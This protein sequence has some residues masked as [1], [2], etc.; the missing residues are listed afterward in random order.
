MLSVT[1]AVA[2]AAA[3]AAVVAKVDG[4]IAPVAVAADRRAVSSIRLVAANRS[5]LAAANSRL[6][7]VSTSRIAVA[8]A[9]ATTVADVVIVTVAAAA[10][11]T[12]AAIAVAIPVAAA[13]VTVVAAV[14]LLRP[15]RKPRLRKK[16]KSKLWLTLLG[17]W[18][19]RL[20]CLSLT[21]GTANGAPPSWHNTGC[22]WP[23][24]SRGDPA[25][26]LR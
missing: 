6:A 9:H 4:S 22:N 7:V 5:R 13:A 1:A 23:G 8:K 24:L 20:L 17:S 15:P 11:A 25:G 3:I 10:V 26:F 12:V 19:A 18:L 2:V 16:S 21:I 14:A